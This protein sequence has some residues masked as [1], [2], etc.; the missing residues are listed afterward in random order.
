MCDKPHAATV[1]LPK[2]NFEQDNQPV[3]HRYST[4][5]L[6]FTAFFFRVAVVMEPCLAA[7]DQRGTVGPLRAGVAKLEITDRAAGPVNDPCFV[8]ALE[9]GRAHV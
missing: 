3:Q 4:I 7:T 6:A 1:A 9:I 8:K 5:L 2:N